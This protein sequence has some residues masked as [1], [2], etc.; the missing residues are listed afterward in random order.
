METSLIRFVREEDTADILSIYEPYIRDTTVTFECEVP[1]ADEFRSRIQGI[2]AVYPYIVCLIDGKTA[3]YAYANKQRDRAA[4]RWNAELSVYIG[5]SYQR[6]GIGKALYTCLIEILRLQH[7]QNVY[8]GVTS[9][10][11]S[12][13]KLHECLGFE[14]LGTYHHT[15]CKFHTW[16]DVT[17]F[18]RAIGSHEPE[19]KAFLP[20][21]EIDE[22]VIHEIM[23]KCSDMIK[24]K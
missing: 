5:Q 3:G 20:V 18:E 9:P 2:S 13:E 8:G 19:P 6:I 10:N 14:K 17:W 4:Y 22:S 21:R 1:S 7:I 16:H 24:I 11:V 12:S 23:D 15:G